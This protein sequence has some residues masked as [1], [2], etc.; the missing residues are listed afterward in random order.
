[1]PHQT[2]C[3]VAVLCPLDG[4]SELTLSESSVKCGGCPNYNCPPEYNLRVGMKKVTS[5]CNFFFHGSFNSPF[6]DYTLRF[7]FGFL[8]EVIL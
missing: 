4:R 6:L 5:F 8:N 1:M 7:S 2:L 3:H